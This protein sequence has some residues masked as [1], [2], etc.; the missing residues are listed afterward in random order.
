V[1]TSNVTRFEERYFELLYLAWNNQEKNDIDK[2]NKRVQW[3]AVGDD[4][5]VWFIENLLYT[6]QHYN[7]SNV[8]Y[9]GDISDKTVQIAHHRDYY[10][11]G[12]GGVLLSRPL[13]LRFSQHTQECKRFTNMFAGDAMI[14][15]CVTAV[16]KVNLT[17]NSNFHQMDHGGDNSGILESGVDGL[18]SLHHMFCIWKPFFDEHA[19]KINE[20]MYLLELAYNTF[21][22]TFLKR[23]VRFNYKT[24]QTLLITLGYSF[25]IFS[26]ILSH[27][28]L[29]EIEKTWCCG[30]MVERRTRP[31]EKN[32]ATWHFRRV[33]TGAFNGSIR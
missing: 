7:S 20:T 11:Y 5:T 26:R 30:E 15:K 23:Y 27:A 13:V 10:A 31:K 2:K 8:I 6:L 3:F 9:L 1:Q 17:R 22:K 33:M 12:G 19:D 24:K 25:S 28:E 14:G 32:K 16:L 18:V 4:D 29:T 21:K